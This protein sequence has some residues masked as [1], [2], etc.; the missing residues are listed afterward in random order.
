V[1]LR[2][3]S[4]IEGAEHHLLRL[5]NNLL[6]I[7]RI[8][9][10]DLP[11]ECAEVDIARL[12]AEAVEGVQT[13]AAQ[14]DIQVDLKHNGSPVKLWTSELYLREVFGNL[15]SNAVKYTPDGGRVTV[16]A[17]WPA[18]ADADMFAPP[19]GEQRRELP[20]VEGRAARPPVELRTAGEGG[21]SGE[22]VRRVQALPRWLE[23]SVI[24]TGY[25]MSKDEQ[26][27]LFTR[28]H[29]GARPEIRRQRGTGLGLAL[30]KRMVERL[31]GMI[32]VRS[33]P[34][35]GST[36]TVIL[37]AASEHVPASD[38]LPSPPTPALS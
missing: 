31:G 5:V 25:G 15:L 21:K 1:A 7:A 38:A 20:P 33:A 30:S 24:D 34:D 13:V 9:R 11:L 35:R 37:P 18:L 12:L 36:F 32:S 27:R 29:R 17:T 10:P 19:S 3:I 8:E 2:Y 26:S 23:V 4:R 16:I 14:K 28:F 6:D 22:Q